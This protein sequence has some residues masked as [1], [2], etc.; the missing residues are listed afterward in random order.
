MVAC[1]F[2]E[3]SGSTCARTSP[4]AAP[5]DDFTPALLGV[6]VLPAS[7]RRAAG[8]GAAAT[9]VWLAVGEMLVFLSGAGVGDANGE[10]RCGICAV[11]VGASF[12]AAFV[13]F[14]AFVGGG[15]GFAGVSADSTEAACLTGAPW[16]RIRGP[17]K[18]A[19][20]ARAAKTPRTR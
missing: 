20:T 6:A 5:G 15:N 14:F 19:T 16:L 3:G 10:G 18:T 13:G 12:G 7:G 11:C 1:A 9:F 8:A 2:C 4:G 17:T